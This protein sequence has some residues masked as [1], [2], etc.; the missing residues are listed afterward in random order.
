VTGFGQDE[1]KARTRAAG[2][3]HHLVKPVKMDALQR[4]LA[5]GPKRS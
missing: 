2:F 3:D 4:A 1:D 5:A